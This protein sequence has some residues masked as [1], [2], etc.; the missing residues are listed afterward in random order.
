MSGT[1]AA[2]T[3]RTGVVREGRTGHDAARAGI[4]AR[5]GAGSL[6]P[7]GCFRALDDDDD[8]AR[9]FLQ[10]TGATK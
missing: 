10:D 7:H 1:H 5:D 9:D 2:S 6:G 4:S 3:P 8:D